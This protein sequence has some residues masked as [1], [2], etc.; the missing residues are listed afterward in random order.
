LPVGVTVRSSREPT[1]EPEKWA[2]GAG[3]VEI[4]PH[5][6]S[7]RAVDVEGAVRTER[8]WRKL[9]VTTADDQVAVTRRH[10]QAGAV[11]RP[12]TDGE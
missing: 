6:N 11:A 4:G 12:S 3:S 1:T 8:R 2:G 10:R 9:A 5:L 7:V